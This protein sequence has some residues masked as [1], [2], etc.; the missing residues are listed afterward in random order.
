MRRKVT[1]RHLIDTCASL[2][3][4]VGRRQRV[5]SPCLQVVIAEA[6]NREQVKN[7]L[8]K[9]EDV[10]LSVKKLLEK[11]HEASRNRE[12]TKSVAE[13]CRVYKRILLPYLEIARTMTIKRRKLIRKLTRKVENTEQLLLSIDVAAGQRNADLTNLDR[14]HASAEMVEQYLEEF[15]ASRDASGVLSIAS[16]DADAVFSLALLLQM[17]AKGVKPNPAKAVLHFAR[18]VEEG[19]VRS[20]IHLGMLLETG[21]KGEKADPAKATAL[22]D[23]RPCESH[24]PAGSSFRRRSRG[25]RCR[26]CTRGRSRYWRR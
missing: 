19:H 23:R 26:P 7:A 25:G 18:A 2:L 6:L 14:A 10:C 4:A 21:A 15:T 22:Y 20:M 8:G 11:L 9:I 17:G 5:H 16:S 3:P 1:E 24:V 12:L 13:V